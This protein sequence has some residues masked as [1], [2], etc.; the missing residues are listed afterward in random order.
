MGGIPTAV[1]ADH[2][3]FKIC[4]PDVFPIGGMLYWI[5]KESAVYGIFEIPKQFIADVN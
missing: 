3:G 4:P 1:T 5:V 2:Y